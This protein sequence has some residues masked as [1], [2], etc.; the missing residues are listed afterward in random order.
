MGGV[1]LA[2]VL[3][4]WLIGRT[5]SAGGK[6]ETGA[7][8]RVESSAPREKWHGPVP[9]VIAERFMKAKSHKERLE[10]VRH[11]EQVG[12]A[13]EAFFRDGPGATEHVKGFHP[14]A[15]SPSGELVFESYHVE[16]AN[17]PMRLLSVLVDPRGAKVDFECYARSG[18]VAWADLLT[19]NVTEAAEVRVMLEAGGY[20]LH[21]FGDEQK[22]LHFKATSP[23]FSETLDFYLDRQNPSVRDIRELGARAFF[24][25]LSIRAVNGSEK[26]R[27]FEITAVKALNW[28]EPD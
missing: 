12:P 22:W 21:E 6:K 27:Q 8:E 23:D 5:H 3:G 16:M 19:G 17:A 1:L 10:L 26:R 14:V 4:L 15:S 20:Y 28:V 11:P 18:S 7:V 9:S 24:A 25:T 13:M 2:A